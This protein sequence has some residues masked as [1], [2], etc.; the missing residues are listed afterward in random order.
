MRPLSTSTQVI[1]P[2]AAAPALAETL[3]LPRVGQGSEPPV[4]PVPAPPLPLPWTAIAWQAAG[5]WAASRVV[6]A[7]ATFFA[8]TLGKNQKISLHAML[9]LWQQWD[10]GR[11]VTIIQAGYNQP[12]NTAFFPLFPLLASGV[13]HII[14]LSHALLAG[15]IVANLAALVAFIG[16][17]L[18]AARE[19]GGADD[20]YRAVRALA[21][22]PLAFFL[23]AAYT[24]SVFLATAVFAL[25]FARR[26]NWIRAALLAFLT[27]LSRPTALILVL[28]LL[29]EF[30]RQQGWWRRETYRNGGWKQDFGM[31]PIAQGL[32]VAAAVPLA[33]A[34]YATYLFFTFGDPLIFQK[35]Q[36]I[37]W[38]RQT[39]P[40]WV[41]LYNIADQLIHPH[42][43]V[44][45]VASVPGSY[46]RGLQL[47]DIG[48]LALFVVL[49]VL[50]AR[51]MPLAYTLY[52]VGLCLLTLMVGVPGRPDV[53]QSTG[54]F[55]VVAFPIFMMVSQWAKMRPWLNTLLID[56]GYVL[57]G[58]F[59]VLWLFGNFIE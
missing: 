25:Y 3:R 38:E 43:L 40:P 1:A 53:I 57:L 11:Y 50:M 15:M 7:I 21:G 16:I 51:R 4:D 29:W 33:I 35:V 28:P 18:L 20:G 32:L 31:I 14:G 30:G 12:D 37:T 2:D 6:L 26:G 55:L 13:A 41:A 17:A 8:I 58:L 54:R 22:Y 47:I 9:G 44:K 34:S 19:F 36:A 52:M 27:G 42:L 46:W 48:F 23:A 24:E 49:T 56:G 39:A 59:T 10:A 5:V 45:G